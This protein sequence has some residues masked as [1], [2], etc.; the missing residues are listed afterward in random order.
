M[1]NKAAEQVIEAFKASQARLEVDARAG[2]APYADGVLAILPPWNKV[3]DLEAMKVPAAFVRYTTTDT[4]A[5]ISQKLLD[6]LQ[7]LALEETAL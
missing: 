1:E 5:A 3:Q 7:C 2:I 4:A 6:A